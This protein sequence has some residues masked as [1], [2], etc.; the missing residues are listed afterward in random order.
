M[1]VIKPEP[2]HVHDWIQL[3]QEFLQE[4]IDQYAWGFSSEDCEAT[5]FTWLKEC[6]GFLLE[7]EGA[8]VGVLAGNIAIHPFCYT[9][10][11]FHE[12]M[13]FVRKSHRGKGGGIKLY[14]A[15]EQE[16]RDRGIKKMVFAHTSLLEVK[17]FK[18]IY[19]KLGFHELETHYVKDIND[20]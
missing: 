19:N 15:C 2:K 8:I 7:E 16:C 1:K 20:A 11:Y 3:V 5:Y 13:W 10:V 18:K 9:T 12:S 17:T 14:E 4:G 6:I